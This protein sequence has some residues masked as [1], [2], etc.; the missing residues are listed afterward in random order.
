[1]LSP[2]DAFNHSSEM[3][4]TPSSNFQNPVFGFQSLTLSFPSLAIPSSITGEKLNVHDMLSTIP[5]KRHHVPSSPPPSLSL[6]PASES[7]A[8]RKAFPNPFL[9]CSITKSR[10]ITAN[11]LVSELQF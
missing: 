11:F 10:Q 4:V 1:L 8:V 5:L 2:P 9:V 3:V 7:T 6:P